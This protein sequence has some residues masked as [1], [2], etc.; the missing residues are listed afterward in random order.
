MC[1]PIRIIAEAAITIRLRVTMVV[2]MV[3]PHAH[4][5][6]AITQAVEAQAPTQEALLRVAVQVVAAAEAALR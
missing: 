1:F 2:I 4:L 3:V 6:P 5:I